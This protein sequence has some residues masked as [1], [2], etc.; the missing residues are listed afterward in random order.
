MA[1]ITP[2][3]PVSPHPL[4]VRWT[5]ADNSSSEET[6]F[7]PLRGIGQHSCQLGDSY[8]C[9]PLFTLMHFTLTLS[10]FVAVM[11]EYMSQLTTT[12]IILCLPFP[13]PPT[14]CVWC[15]IP[16]FPIIFIL[17]YLLPYLLEKAQGILWKYSTVAPLVT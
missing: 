9:F 4:L 10:I 14:L 5:V 17:P 2:L 12:H 13:A 1:V 16:F 8:S 6:F 3:T 7:F 15:H 11:G